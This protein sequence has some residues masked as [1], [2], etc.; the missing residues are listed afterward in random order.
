MI[1]TSRDIAILKDL[2][3]YGL[4]TTKKLS[5]RHFPGVAMTTVL[6]RLR[7]LERGG[8]I[9]RI[10]GL[11]AGL[12][13]WALTKASAKALLPQPSKAHFPRFILDHDLK[14][15]DLRLSLEAAGISHSWRPEHEIRANVAAKYGLKNIAE[16]VIPDGLMAV[17]IGGLREAV[18]VELE[19]SPKNQRRYRRLFADY[20]TKKNLWG[21]WYVVQSATIG[22]QLMRAARESWHRG[23][24]PF[25]L[26]SKL[27]DILADPLN[28]PVHTYTDTRLLGELWTQ[29][30]STSPAHTPA[31]GMSRE[32]RIA[33]KSPSELSAPNEPNI[34]VT[35]D[36][37]CAPPPPLA[38][39]TQHCSCSEGGQCLRRR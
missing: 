39:R 7:T 14:L 4:F 37:L 17:E 9:Q 1:L 19:L 32:S 21:F 25:F 8:H 15:V 3:R 12:N 22:R 24:C 26:W 20:G 33:A 27:D 23:N 6:R 38:T 34:P 2:Q 10:A 30:N 28:A 5:E 18:A 31:H 36:V 13:A 11:E 16:R 35:R 29:K